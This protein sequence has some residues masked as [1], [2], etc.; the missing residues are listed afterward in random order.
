MQAL[1]K[2]H[3]Y[4]ILAAIIFLEM[5]VYGGIINSYSIYTVPITEDFGIGRGP[6]SIADLNYNIFSF[7]S[8]IAVGMLFPKYGYRKIATASLLI[9]TIAL[10]LMSFAP[11]LLVYGICRALFGIGHGAC[12]TAGAVKIIRSWFFRH[13]GLILGLVT[14][15]TGIGGSI[16][17]PA[18]T[19]I[20]I[21]A[22]W[23]NA[24]RF[25]ALLLFLI[26]TLYLLIRD[27]PQELGL[28][29]FGIETP[30]TSANKQKVDDWQGYTGKI[31]Y[32]KPL[33]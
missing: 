31:I 17:A 18:L 1:L 25:A 10:V 28:K 22:G 4:W 20:I 27:D 14:M 13:Q 9:S 11:N 29:Q 7:I 12:F 23:R 33:F 15:S 21:T 2:K 5:I 24:A 6:L 3:Y 16:L 26:T 30:V 8:T 19:E 32:R